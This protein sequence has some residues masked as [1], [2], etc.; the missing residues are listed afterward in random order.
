MTETDWP[1]DADRDDPL[2]ELRIPVT[3]AHPDHAYLVALT[4]GRD[5]LLELFGE[6]ALRPDGPEA[7]RI[8]SYIRYL[9]SGYSA[10]WQRKLAERP[11]DLDGARAT[12]VLRK[13]AED[14]W[15]YRLST[16]H[17]PRWSTRHP[18]TGLAGLLDHIATHGG[19]IERPGWA[20]WKAAHPDVFAAASAEPAAPADDVQSLLRRDAASFAEEVAGLDVEG[21]TQRTLAAITGTAPAVT[22]AGELREAARL[23]RERAQGALCDGA[24]T[25]P[26]RVADDCECECCE[27]VRDAAGALVCQADDRQSAHLASMHPGVALAVA[28]WLDSV[29]RV[30]ESDLTDA[31]CPCTLDDGYHHA[32]SVARAYLGTGGDR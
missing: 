20:E 24:S 10:L 31:P 15:C 4:S 30:I 32:A 8:A 26:W 7:A 2:A 5:K 28:G 16:W 9:C 12:V 21:F 29:A 17:S 13:R 1:F 6:T 27:N 23:M 19:V 22:P 14:D 18:V 3:P 25:L 11:F